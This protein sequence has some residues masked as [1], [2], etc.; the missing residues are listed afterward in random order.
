MATQ[1]LST[2]SDIPE[3]HR[4]DISFWVEPGTKVRI[5]LDVGETVVDG[6]VPLTL[7]IEQA[8]AGPA[9]ALAI[10]QAE[11]K[12]IYE[13]VVPAPAAVPAARREWFAALKSRLS[14]YHLA[15]WLFF[16]AIVIYL[17]TRL[18]GLTQFPIYFFTD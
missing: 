9:P 4:E 15:A 5:T 18:I 7:H 1:N 10:P 11:Q 14:S 6:K 13:A 8:A 17:I 12:P 16:F 3:P 2:S